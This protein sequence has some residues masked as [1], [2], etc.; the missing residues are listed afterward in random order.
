MTSVGAY[1]FAACTGLTSVT[2][3]N[4]V[5]RIEKKCVFRLHGPANGHARHRSD[6][7]RTVRVFPNGAYLGH[8]PRA[9]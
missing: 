1:A 8:D 6:E 9:V 2:I 5:T 7:H 4:T 3:S